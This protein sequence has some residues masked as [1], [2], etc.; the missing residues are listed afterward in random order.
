RELMTAPHT[1]SRT[2]FRHMYWNMAQQLAHV[3]VNGAAVRPGDLYASG[4]ISGPQ[5]DGYGSFIELTWRGTRPLTLPSGEVR[6]F[7]EDADTVTLRGCAHAPGKPKIGFGQ[8]AGTILP[9]V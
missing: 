6:S 8:V 5:A 7:L 1:V 4:T 2:N 3:T 9:C